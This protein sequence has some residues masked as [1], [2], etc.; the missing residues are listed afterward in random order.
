MIDYEIGGKK[1]W[2][3]SHARANLGA[4]FCRR[5]DMDHSDWIRE[6]EEGEEP[7]CEECKWM[8]K[9]LQSLTDIREHR[10][11]EICW[12]CSLCGEIFDENGAAGKEMKGLIKHLVEYHFMKRLPARQMAFGSI[13]RKSVLD[14]KLGRAIE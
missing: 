14:R 3:K 4:S 5:V 9:G 7:T 13:Y 10:D 11:E 1:G 2:T 12:Y 8:M 6:V